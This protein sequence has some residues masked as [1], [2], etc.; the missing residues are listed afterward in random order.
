MNN[1]LINLVNEEHK[2]NGNIFIQPDLKC[3]EN[4]LNSD[5]STLEFIDISAAL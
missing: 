3:L 1:I 4:I 5:K 2:H